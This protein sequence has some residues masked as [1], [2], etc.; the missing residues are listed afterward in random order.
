MDAYDCHS[1][2]ELECNI[3]H[4][5]RTASRRKIRDTKLSIELTDPI[6]PIAHLFDLH[7]L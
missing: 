4:N 6:V 5:W 7:Q 2:S 1:P 3:G